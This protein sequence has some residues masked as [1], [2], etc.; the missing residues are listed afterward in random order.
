M[1]DIGSINTQSFS[2]VYESG[3]NRGPI[4]QEPYVK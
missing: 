2:L 1:T 4:W 3:K